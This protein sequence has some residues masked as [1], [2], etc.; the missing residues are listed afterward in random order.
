MLRQPGIEFSLRYVDSD[1]LEIVVDASNGS[2]GGRVELYESFANVQR[3]ASGLKGFP[4]AGSRD[5]RRFELGTFDDQFAGDGATFRLYCVDEA[6]HIAVDLE[7][8]TAA[9][10]GR[11]HGRNVARFQVA[12]EPALIDRF[13]RE[14]ESWTPKL[15][16]VARLEGTA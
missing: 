15:G 14:F 9:Y 4:V 8:R 5:E 3:F 13:I 12:T 7:L 6:G 1:V 11:T 10:N 2:F 16:D